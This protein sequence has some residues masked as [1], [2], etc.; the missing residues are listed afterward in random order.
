MIRAG[1]PAKREGMRGNKETVN[2]IAVDT[3]IEDASDQAP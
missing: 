3:R 2:W 1:I